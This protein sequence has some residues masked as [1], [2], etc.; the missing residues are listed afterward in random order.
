M[1]STRVD[2]YR[3]NKNVAQGILAEVYQEMAMG[4][5]T[6]WAKAVSNAVAARSGFPLMTAA[7]YK[8]G[9][10]NVNVGEWMWG[11]QFN[12]SQSLSFAGFFGYIEPTNSPN[13]SFKARY[14]DIFV[15]STF[16]SLFSATDVRN[17]FLPAPAQS[18]SRPWKKWVTTKFQDNATQSGDYVEMRSSEM[19][20]I[21][22]EGLAQQNQLEAAKDALF[23]LQKQRDPS[24][25]RSIAATKDALINE[26]LVERRKELYAEIGVEYF[27]LKRYQRA[28]VRDGIQWSLITVPANDNRWR[29]QI[30]QT[31]MDANK[32]LTAADQNPL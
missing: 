6:L 13:S 9:F 8:S 29:W 3:F 11:I 26:I 2:K 27:D 22:A 15:N 7:D 5:A 10:N 31:E 18:S 17:L 23:I 19:Y 4:D 21:E 20:L 16:V 24:A 28:M 30:P 1:T 12:A 32:A 25:I 14:N